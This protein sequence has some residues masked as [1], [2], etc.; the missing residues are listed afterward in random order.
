MRCDTTGRP[1]AALPQALLAEE[2]ELQDQELLCGMF[3]GGPVGQAHRVPHRSDTE[4]ADRLNATLGAHGA[5]SSGRVRARVQQG[6]VVLEGLATS[7]EWQELEHLAATVEG[8]AG[9]H[10]F[11]QQP[12]QSLVDNS[13]AANFNRPQARR[14]AQAGPG[15]MAR[16]HASR[17]AD[18]LAGR[19]RRASA[20]QLKQPSGP[21]A[22]RLARQRAH[23][24]SGDMRLA[25]GA[26][27]G[28]APRPVVREAGG[29]T[30]ML[31]ML[32]TTVEA[33]SW[34]R[35]CR[36]RWPRGR[37]RSG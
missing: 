1:S 21:P 26:W 11:V 12:R 16:T 37:S 23:R 31:N 24:P 15:P 27:P 18:P 5:V 2:E 19:S 30:S 34:T 17:R 6:W 25:R 36:R 9:V 29:T 4:L 10:A 22:D 28:I 13:W 14:P 7:A 8:V 20:A 33:P 3:G 32:N 35:C